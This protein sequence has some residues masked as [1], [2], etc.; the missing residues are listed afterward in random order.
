MRAG[1]AMAQSASTV[2]QRGPALELTLTERS[3][4]HFVADTQS[5]QG[6][7]DPA[8]MWGNVDKM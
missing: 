2:C 1:G 6:S 3:A 7:G 8:D 4:S 5:E